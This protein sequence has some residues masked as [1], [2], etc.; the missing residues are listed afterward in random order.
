MTDPARHRLSI[1][2]V[3]GIRVGHWTDATARTGCTVILAD[4]HGMVAGM[5]DAVGEASSAASLADTYQSRKIS[6]SVVVRSTSPSNA[7]SSSPAI[8]Y[9]CS[10]AG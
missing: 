6:A 10:G 3:P 5:D 2:D 9:S 1:R 4:D 7:R 8:L